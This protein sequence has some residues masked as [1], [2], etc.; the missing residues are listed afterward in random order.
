MRFEKLVKLAGRFLVPALL[1]SMLLAQNSY[2]SEVGSIKA[3]S[4]TLSSTVYDQLPSPVLKLK[5]MKAMSGFNYFNLEVT[6]YSVYPDEMFALTTLPSLTFGKKTL[7]SR[8]WVD[9]YNAETNQYIYGVTSCTSAASLNDILFKCTP[10][11]IPPKSIYIK[12]SDIIGKKVYQSN[13]IEI[14][15]PLP[16]PVAKLKSKEVKNGFK[17]FNLEVTNYS[18]YPDGIFAPS[19]NLPAIG[20]NTSASRT[21]VDIY[22]AETNQYIYGF[23][24][25]TKAADMNGI[26]FACPENQTP[27][28]L[29]YIKLTDRLTNQTY[30]SNNVVIYKSYTDKSITI[31]DRLLNAGT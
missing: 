7:T 8:T 25:L 21:R 12:L 27:P 19:P 3:E 31:F 4:N 23:V 5:S 6:N 15:N 24:A 20:N 9:I 14:Y 29:V 10:N 30:Q 26:W 13:T 18:A 17:Y 22:N 16:N 2:A 11:Q 28:R 1:F